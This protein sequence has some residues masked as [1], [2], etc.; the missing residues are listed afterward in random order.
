[1]T[2]FVDTSAFF[3]ALAEDDPAHDEALRWLDAVATADEHLLTHSYV[4]VEST[5]LI[6]TRLG[7]A[8]VRTFLEDMLPVCEIRFV[9]HALHE[10]A[11]VGY[12]AALGRRA[13]FVDRVS[14][15]LMRSERIVRAFSFDRDFAREGFDTVP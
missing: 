1:V 10:R 6:H 2:T 11:T 8:A 15:E 4:A 5:A 9:D 13:S 14:F 7:T 3:A 12:L